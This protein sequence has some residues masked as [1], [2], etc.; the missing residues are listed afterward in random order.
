MQAL[1]QLAVLHRITAGG[2]PVLADPAGHPLGQALPHVLRIGIEH[3][4][5]R[6][7]QR[8]Q[9]GNGR[10]QL[11]PVVGGVRFAATQFA[12]VALVAQQRSP[13]AGAGI[14]EAGSVGVDFDGFQYSSRIR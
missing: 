11:H 7:G 13:A 10:H 4:V 5:A 8:L 6:L 3:D 14:A 1:P 2:L 9:P 12:L